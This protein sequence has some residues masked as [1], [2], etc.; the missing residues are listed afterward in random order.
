ME[1]VESPCRPGARAC[2]PVRAVP[3]ADCPPP[4]GCDLKIGGVALCGWVC[5]RGAR[6]AAVRVFL[7]GRDWSRQGVRECGW[8]P[9][10]VPFFDLVTR[11]AVMEGPGTRAARARVTEGAAFTGARGER[12]GERRGAATATQWG[13][14][15][16]LSCLFFVFG[17]CVALFVRRR[18]RR[19]R[20]RR[21]REK[22]SKKAQ[23][24]RLPPFQGAPHR[25]RP[26]AASAAAAAARS[27]STAASDS[28]H[29]RNSATHRRQATQAARLSGAS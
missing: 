2:G 22:E 9:A 8:G 5:A 23:I 15:H 4:L 16:R 26:A 19:R 27:R 6:A 20:R 7:F 28:G 1:R 11:G 25:S 24:S 14:G 12:G 29:R 10:S 21:H 3:V 13:M 17:V 18:R